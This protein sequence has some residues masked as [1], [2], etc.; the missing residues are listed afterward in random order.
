MKPSVG[1]VFAWILTTVVAVLVASAAVGSVRRQIT[2]EP[3]ALRPP[4]TTVAAL[5]EAKR[6]DRV[7]V[8][9]TSSDAEAQPPEFA[10]FAGLATGQTGREAGAK[11]SP[12]PTAG[13][14]DTL[15]AAPT[16]S[17]D[18]PVATPSPTTPVATTTTRAPVAATATIGSRSQAEEESPPSPPA[19]VPPEQEENDPPPTTTSTTTTSTTTTTTTTSP[20]TTTTTTVPPTRTASFDLVGGTVTVAIDAGSVSL[21]SAS[22]RGGFTTFVQHRGPHRVTVV[23]RSWSHKSTF[24]GEMEGDF[25]HHIEEESIGRDDENDGDDDH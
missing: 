18:P 6:P 16:T 2:D 4:N 7:P 10:S 11:A 22:P 15:A 9:A 13:A 19:T 23:F 24:A 1:M 17:T 12:P 25:H 8:V 14:T 20:P 3:L 5:A 21:L